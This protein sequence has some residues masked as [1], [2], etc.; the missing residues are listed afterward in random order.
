MKW[1]PQ[2]DLPLMFAYQATFNSAYGQLILQ[3]LLDNIYCTVYE[4]TN[5]NE[6]LV[7]NARRSVVHEILQMIDQA[8][9]PPVAVEMNQNGGV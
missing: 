9:H 5:P 3:H 4:G 7:H 8:Q 1:R 2:H 6:A